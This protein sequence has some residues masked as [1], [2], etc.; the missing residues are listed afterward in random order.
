MAL[1]L[2]GPCPLLQVFDMPTSLAFYCGQLGFEVIQSS[3]VEPPFDW[4][5]LRR[6]G[7]DLML[8]TAFEAAHRPAE[9][10][11]ARWKAHSD[12]QLYFGCADVDEAFRDLEAKGVNVTPPVVREFGMK[13]LHF[14]D[15]DGYALC[16]Q[17][18]V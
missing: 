13:Q 5:W 11:D 1:D 12:T 15:P 7:A 14:Q 10:D 18:R 8:N 6:E 16:F 3:R 2:L 17:M 4:V 9:R